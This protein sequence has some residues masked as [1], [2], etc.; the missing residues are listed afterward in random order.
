CQGTFSTMGADVPAEIRRFLDRGAIHFVHFRDVKG[1]PARFAETFH[2]LGQ[3]DMYE[4]MKVYYDQGYRG[5][6]RPDHVPTMAGED[7]QAPGYQVLG[8]LYALGY[9]HGLGESVEKAA[10]ST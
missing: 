2:D 3:T 8:R 9:M 5:L 7:N 10:A 6:V 1:T 4:A